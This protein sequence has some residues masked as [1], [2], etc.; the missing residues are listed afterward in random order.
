MSA[1]LISKQVSGLCIHV[2]EHIHSY[3]CPIC[4]SNNQF[5]NKHLCLLRV[6]VP[7]YIFIPVQTVLIICHFNIY[8]TEEGVMHV[9]G[10][11]VPLPCTTSN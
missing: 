11:A 5:V 3:M 6:H 2:F 4:K 9:V 8:L 1:F 7:E 10:Y